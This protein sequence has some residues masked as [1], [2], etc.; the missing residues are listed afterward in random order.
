M[1]TVIGRR[2]LRLIVLSNFAG[3]TAEAMRQQRLREYD[4]QSEQYRA[5]LEV[6]CQMR[7]HAMSEAKR[8]LSSLDLLKAWRSWRKSYQ[9]EKEIARIKARTP[10]VRSASIEEQQARAGDEAERRL[11]EFLSEALGD[12][13]TLIA[14]YHG[15]AGEIDRI[16]IGPWGIY[17]FEIKGNRGVIHY[18]GAQW[19]TEK[20]DR[21]GNSLGRK[22]LPRAPDV[23]L[24]K[25][26]EGLERWL[27]RNGVDQRIVKVVLFTAEDAVLGRI[28]R[29]SVECVAT[30]KY[31][32]LGRLFNP[33]S[34]QSA[35]AQ[36]VCERIANLAVR[37]H[38]FWERR[39]HGALETADRR[40]E[41]EVSRLSFAGL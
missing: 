5:K 37:D 39:R 13:W 20:F 22:V 40:G 41:G 8:S 31:L 30:L 14:G 4:E 25:A 3:E 15:R 1:E 10:I 33:A 7:D 17:A 38:L 19:W 9:A 18:D 36:V 27:R 29:P 26:A 16:L 6:A 11:D 12:Q 2:G 23:Q 24:A 32:D 28:E 35:L 21:R 34:K